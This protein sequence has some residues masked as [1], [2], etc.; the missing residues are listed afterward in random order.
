[1]PHLDDATIHELL[2]LPSVTV[3]VGD[4]FADWGRGA[5]ATTQRVRAAAGPGMASAMAAVVPPF[6]G[7]KVYA[8]HEGRFTFVIVL[9][10]P[11]GRFLCT[12]DGDAVTRLRTPATSALA[13]RH[14][15]APDVRVA[16]VVGGGRQSWPHLAM[17]GVELPSLAEVRVFARRPDA[18][19]SLVK[20][21]ADEGIPAV[22]SPSAPA[23]VDGAEVVVTVT[24]AT[25]PLFPAA[26][27]G[28]RTLVCA[29]G[30]TKYDRCEIG[31]DVVQRCVAV[32]ADDVTGSR[33][34][35]GDLLRAEAAGCF[36]WDRA[37]ELHAVVSGT[38]AVPPAG[39]GPVLFES[40][41]VALQD[42]ATAGLAW[43]RYERRSSTTATTSTPTSTPTTRESPS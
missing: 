19:E 1:M 15:A 27:V 33:T 17:L 12:L 32:V 35:C 40:Q 21:A 42:V 36:S 37:V 41:G 30:A 10:G 9:F 16:A 7:G 25:E 14:L 23:A 43:Q 28:D 39:D 2:D 34:E 20:R 8:T 3:A 26:V 13:I 5:A 18:A 4:A 38:T 22:A 31:P 24:S 6:S 29:V 11:A